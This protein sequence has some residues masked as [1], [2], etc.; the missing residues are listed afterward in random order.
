MNKRSP[1]GVLQYYLPQQKVLRGGR[2]E[3]DFKKAGEDSASSSSRRG[4]PQIKNE[5]ALGHPNGREGVFGGYPVCV[6]VDGGKLAA[7][8]EGVGSH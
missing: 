6:T 4:P 7:Q 5:A 2:T 3:L 8:T 1:A